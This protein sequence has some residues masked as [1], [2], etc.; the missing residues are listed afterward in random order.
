M[1]DGS[2][3]ND[4]EKSL[5]KTVFIKT[6]GCQM[7]EYDTDRM[8]SGL[9]QTGWKRVD[10]PEQAGLIVINT[11]SVRD[12]AQQKAFSEIGRMRNHKKNDVVLVVTG[13][14]AQQEG[15]QLLARFPEVDLV[16]GTSR[17]SSLP[18]II[19][20]F[21]IGHRH[22][23]SDTVMDTSEFFGFAPGDIQTF[24]PNDSR[25]SAFVA[26]MTGC[27]NFCSYC[28]VPYVRGSERSRP[29]EDVIR[30]IRELAEIG[31]KEVTL[32]GQ[33]VNSY[34]SYPNFGISFAELLE[35][36]AQIEQIQRIRFTTSHPKDLS[37]DLVEAF[38]EIDKLCNH[39]HLPIQSGSDKIL[40]AMNRGYS[41]ADYMDKI[42]ILRKAN[43]EIAITSDIIVG[44]PQETDKDFE[45]TL[46]V[47]R[48]MQFAG[49]FAFKYSP[50]PRTKAADFEDDVP[51][52]EKNRRLGLVLKTQEALNWKWRRS[53]VG[54]SFSVLVEGPGVGKNGLW[55][56]RTST[57]CIVHFPQ[58]NIMPG[59]IVNV[60]ITDALANS[61]RGEVE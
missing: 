24:F 2:H 6:F 43:P 21:I 22:R 8:F 53:M 33:N 16:I 32:L 19:D 20:K 1:N 58:T 38:S 35:M 17:I 26:I 13:C 51:V 11:C 34:G 49:V 29:P 28:V 25:T 57:S 48:Q 42:Q 9:A 18:M 45:D 60:R 36:V 54:N 14:I 59:D 4:W 46:D 40:T 56:G 47:I 44:F 50:R 15:K 12:K 37:E 61:V 23:I 27:N 52:K 3:F 55:T 10:S 30:E 7:N 31:I 39:L 5:P 41:S